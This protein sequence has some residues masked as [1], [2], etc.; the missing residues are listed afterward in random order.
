MPQRRLDREKVC[1]AWI[2]PG[3][4]HHRFTDSL[5]DTLHDGVW[6][7]S[8]ISLVSGPRI[9]EARS[10]VC[11]AFL[12]NHAD[13]EWLW[14][15][16][17]D[18]SFP[19]ESLR[20]LMEA[21]NRTTRRVMGGLCYAGGHTTLF[22]TIFEA[23]ELEDGTPAPMLMDD[24]VKLKAIIDVQAPVKVAA[25]GA[26]F[27]LVHRSVIQTMR[28]AHPV[29]FGTYADGR[30]NPYPWFAEGQHIGGNALGEDTLFTWRAHL[31]GMGVHVHTGVEIDHW[32]ERSMNTDL[33]LSSPKVI[34]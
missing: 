6:D 17:T 20:R 14:M 29:G 4:V 33:W 10:Q 22:P 19:G 23:R 32:K 26:A 3:K 24:R 27:L 16:D 13:Y 21:A 18:M 12:A 28:Q 34:P 9:A 31:L 7:G 25:T 8:R 5:I 11:D 1:A 15:I 2:S 30:R